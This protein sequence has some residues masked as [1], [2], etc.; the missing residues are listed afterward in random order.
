MDIEIGQ[1]HGLLWACHSLYVVV[2]SEEGTDGRGSGLYRVMDTD[3]DDEFDAIHTLAR[4]EGFGEHGPHS[5]I[6]GPDSLALTLVAGNHTELPDMSHSLVPKVWEEDGFVPALREP[7]GHAADRPPP[8]GWIARTDSAGEHWELVSVGYRN[9]YELAFNQD[10]D[11]FA[12]DSDME[13]DLG[14]PWYRPIRVLHVTSGSE[15]GWRS[16]SAKWPEY[17][18]DNLPSAALYNNS[19]LTTA[20]APVS[21][22]VCKP[23]AGS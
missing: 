6:F 18:P 20:S 1:I 8:G 9:A 13:W 5:V 21:L 16:G 4:F 2:N 19:Y 12:F 11:L 22:P 10:G 23:S 15:F 17:Y 14:M 3:G 7:R